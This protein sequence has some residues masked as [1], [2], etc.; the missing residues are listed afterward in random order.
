LLALTAA[1]SLVG[2]TL[3]AAAMGAA[4]PMILSHFGIDPAMATGIFITPG[5]D[6]L[7]VMVFFLVASLIYL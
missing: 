3:L 7:A 6:I 4:V 5:N 1:L 2:V